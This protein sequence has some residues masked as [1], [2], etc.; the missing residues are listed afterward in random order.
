MFQFT[1]FLLTV[2]VSLFI[3]TQTK[4]NQCDIVEVFTT[5][6]YCSFADKPPASA[7]PIYI[8]YDI[9]PVEGFN[10]RRDVFIRM[11]VFLKNLKQNSDV[12]KNAKLVLPPFSDLYHWRTT[13]IDQN[14]IFWNH[15]FD[16]SSLQN[17]TGVLDIWEFFSELRAQGRCGTIKINRVF[18]LQHFEEMFES[19]VF[20]D[21]FEI[22]KCRSKSVQRNYYLGYRNLT[23][24]QFDCMSFQGS[25]MLLERVLNQY[26]DQ[27]SDKA[28]IILFLNAETVLHEV[29]SN[30]EYWRARRSMRFNKNLIKIANKFRLDRFNS[31]DCSEKVQRPE[32]WLNEKPYRSALGGNY[33]C[34]HL[35]RAD[36]IQGRDKT[37]PTLQSAATQIKKKL[38]ELKVG[39]IFISSDCTRNGEPLV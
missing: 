15:F 18:K 33:L 3:V 31:T 36:F 16:L 32:S 11:A 20:V 5:I 21:K 28:Q 29:W 34:V 10:L 1:A 39:K 37:T 6:N 4:S 14:H 25:A 19:G 2:F 8:L 9:N 24:S 13:G 27:S 38:K 7:P 22:D 12:Y 30:D 23:S 17:Y 26:L 35:R